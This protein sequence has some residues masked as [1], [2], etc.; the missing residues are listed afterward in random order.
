MRSSWSRHPERK[1]DGC[2]SLSPRCSK[3]ATKKTLLACVQLAQIPKQRKQYVCETA[4]ALE[5]T[6]S[7]TLKIHVQR[8]HV[9]RQR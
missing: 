9:A 7:L 8:A 6:L 5:M 3:M 2:T 1:K 4:R